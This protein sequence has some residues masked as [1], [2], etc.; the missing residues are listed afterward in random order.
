MVMRLSQTT[1]FFDEGREDPKSTKRGPSSTC[2]PNAMK[3]AFRWRADDRPTLIAGLVALW[4]SR[5]SGPVW[6]RKPYIFVIFQGGGV[7]TLCPPLDPPMMALHC[8]AVSRLLG[9]YISRSLVD[10][11][12]QNMLY[13]SI[14]KRRFTHLCLMQRLI[15]ISWTNL[16]Q[17]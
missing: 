14:S 1:F 10:L 5:G 7:R 6:L 3:I 16:F 4:F 8:R 15:L 17:I 12:D 13:W 9:R 2:Q 11:I